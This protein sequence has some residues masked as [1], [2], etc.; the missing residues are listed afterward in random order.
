MAAAGR[1]AECNTERIGIVVTVV[2]VINDNLRSFVDILKFDNHSSGIGKATIRVPTRRGVL[3]AVLHFHLEGEHRSR[4]EVKLSRIA[5]PNLVRIHVERHVRSNDGVI[6]VAVIIHMLRIRIRRRDFRNHGI[7]R[8][9]F[10][11]LHALVGNR[12]L[13]VHVLDIDCA[14]ERVGKASRI[15]YRQDN[16]VRGIHR[17][18]VELGTIL[19]NDGH[20]RMVV[21][22]LHVK[23][24]SRN[25]AG[26]RIGEHDSQ[27]AGIVCIHIRNRECMDFST[28]LR[29]FGNL[30]RAV[31]LG[32]AHNALDFRVFVHVRE[33]KLH[34][35][36]IGKAA[37][38]VP[39]RRGVL[40]AVLHFYLEGKRRSRFEVN[41]CRIGYLDLVRIHVERHVRSNDGVFQVAE[42]Y[43]VLRIR[44]RRGK[45]CHNG[46]LRKVFGLRDALVGDCRL[47]VHIPDIDRANKRISLAVNVLD[48]QDN[49]VR[50][51]H[52]F[53]V[54][55]GTILNNDGHFRMVVVQLHVKERSRNAAGHRIGEHDSQ[56]AGIV[57]IHIRNRECMDFSTG[58]RIF[59]NLERAVALGIT[60]DALDFRILVHVLE[61]NLHV[62]RISKAPVGVFARRSVLLAVLHYHS[63]SEFRGRFKVKQACIANP[64]L[65]R[66]HVERNV[67]DDGEVKMAEL[68][69]LGIRFSHLHFTDKRI[70]SNILVRSKVS[71][72]NDRGFIHVEHLNLTDERIGKASIINNRDNYFVKCVNLFKVKLRAILNDYAYLRLGRIHDHIEQ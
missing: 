63:E 59:G 8:E 68:D 55:L 32:I 35:S 33:R 71:V 72:I 64:H 22:Q 36:S 17:F 38:R 48:R 50:G 67:L 51:I 70:I 24:R 49:H 11:L 40:L 43:H 14:D 28:G 45:L 1:I 66:I 47:F 61:R 52:R 26:H 62:S 20:F 9:V 19:N 23:E 6:Q 58:L 3:L 37:V 18:V 25:A 60:H 30:E 69:I 53:V 44:I 10:R 56:L 42:I 4:F 65:V 2:I 12:R 54:E 16:H 57:C 27:L 31:A 15:L 41:L 29:I 7:L 13:L 5:Y 46:I 34:G 21:V 39:T